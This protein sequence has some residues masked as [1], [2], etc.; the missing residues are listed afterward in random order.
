MG[1]F[2]LA[3]IVQNDCTQVQGSFGTLTHAAPE[4]VLEGLLSKAAGEQQTGEA[5]SP[6]QPLTT[7]AHSGAIIGVSCPT[8]SCLSPQNRRPQTSTLS[9]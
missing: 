1:D 7:C 5:D 2:G 3:Q 4:L 6:P 8:N 9:A